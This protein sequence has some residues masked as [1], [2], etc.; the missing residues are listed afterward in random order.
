MLCRCA[1]FDVKHRLAQ[2]K[3][4]NSIRNH[5][6]IMRLIYL[7]IYFIWGLSEIEFI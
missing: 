7:C 5:F 1:E 2:R 4:Q 3:E 6:E